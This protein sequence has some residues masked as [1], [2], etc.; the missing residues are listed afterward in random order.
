MRQN[1][2]AILTATGSVSR[3][4]LLMLLWRIR[5]VDTW[6]TFAKLSLTQ[7]QESVL[8]R[9]C[10]PASVIYVS[11]FI[12]LLHTSK[13]NRVYVWVCDKV[14]AVPLHEYS[15]QKLWDWLLSKWSSF[16]FKIWENHDRVWS[17]PGLICINI[18]LRIC[19]L[20]IVLK[21]D[22]M[23]DEQK[24]WK[25][26]KNKHKTKQDKKKKTTTTTTR[27]NKQQKQNHSQH[28]NCYF[29]SCMSEL[30]ELTLQYNQTLRIFLSPS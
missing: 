23:I 1:T 27:Q 10:K 17:L 30:N 13:V 7:I 5:E 3:C 15:G 22:T 24:H 21:L 25:T 4:F 16:I 11:K 26:L 14:H 19:S 8:V 29:T 18:L 12:L 6:S 20:I 9:M 28:I 2:C